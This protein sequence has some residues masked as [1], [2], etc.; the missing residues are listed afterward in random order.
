MWQ[1]D[2]RT[3]KV[4]YRAGA[5]LT[6]KTSM[7]NLTMYR[8][9]ISGWVKL[10]NYLSPILSITHPR[11]PTVHSDSTPTH[12][13]TLFIEDRA[14]PPCECAMLSKLQERTPTLVYPAHPS[15]STPTHTHPPVQTPLKTPCFPHRASGLYIPGCC[16]GRWRGAKAGTSG[17]AGGEGGVRGVRDVMVYLEYI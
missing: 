11:P 4:R 8:G 17:C 15:P 16:S 14:P 3:S 6:A 1:T 9:T 13:C 12:L 5:L 10:K 7:S 2:R